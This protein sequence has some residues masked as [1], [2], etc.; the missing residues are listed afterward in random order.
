MA[1]VNNLRAV[2]AD[3]EELHDG[4]VVHGSDR[5]LRGHVRS[6]GDHRIAMAFGIL[7]SLPGNEIR[8]DNDDV[9][10]VSFPDFWNQL[11]LCRA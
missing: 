7:G 10:A 11:A 6:H 2:G 8:V 9:V 5:P 3:A 4:L 1:M